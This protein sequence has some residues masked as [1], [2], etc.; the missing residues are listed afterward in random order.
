MTAESVAGS[1]G[2][3]L[4][5]QLHDGF[6]RARAL[7]LAAELDVADLLGD[8][9]RTADDLAAATATHPGALYRLLRL[10]AGCGVLTEVAPR[11]FA[12]TTEGGPLRGDHPHSVKATLLS[13]RLFLPVYADALHS[14]RTGEPAFPRTYGAPLFEYLQ[15]HPDQ[16]TLF[17]AAMADASRLETAA[18]LDAVDLGGARHVVDV[19]GGSGTLLGAVLRRHP[20]VTGVVL[21]RP[22]LAEAARTHAAA[23][24]V[25][26]RL[27][28]TGGDFFREV[29]GGGDVYLLKS[30]VHDWPDDAA[31]DILRICR[32][33]MP[34]GGR[35]LLVERV[36]PAGD[37]DHP[38]KAMDFTLLVVLGG[39]ERTEAEYAAL[40]SA[41][42]LRCTGVTPTACPL[43]VVEA[44][45][46]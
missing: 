34:P 1:A 17:H 23:E 30:I 21:D 5:G 6:V 31:V 29:P 37:G 36:L 44:V 11:R 40:L 10:L 42:G 45:P 18:L 16:A 7:Q 15:E 35:L 39:R 8:G 12:L 32:A 14:L 20:G 46:A 24:G 27:T 25:A 26:D 33:A 38:G 3:A 9:D 41:A 28:F 22:H 43:S 4:L 2:V 13:A 19:G